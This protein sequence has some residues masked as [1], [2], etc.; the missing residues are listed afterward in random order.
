MIIAVGLAILQQ[1]TGINTILYYGSMIFTE[2]A[3]QTASSAI[4]ANT[5]I[6][7]INFI[8]PIVAMQDWP[9]GRFLVLRSDVTRD[10]L[11]NA[12]AR[13]KW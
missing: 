13:N 1:V 2:H 4:G 11:R 5:L 8:V 6:G 10:R 9:V 7:G 12:S 3:S